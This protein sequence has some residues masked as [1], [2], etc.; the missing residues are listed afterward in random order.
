MIENRTMRTET[1]PV[2]EPAC[3][4]NG[5]TAGQLTVATAGC[6]DGCISRYK[7]IRI[8]GRLSVQHTG[9]TFLPAI[10]QADKQPCL[11]TA[12]LTDGQLTA[13][14]ATSI[15]NLIKMFK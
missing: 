1:E 15:I 7:T 2:A 4:R 12:N 14:T 3:Q 9:C 5:Q 10:G 11:C 6:I 8:T 13:L